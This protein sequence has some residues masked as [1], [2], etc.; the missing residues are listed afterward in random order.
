MQPCESGRPTDLQRMTEDAQAEV[1]GIQRDAENSFLIKLKPALATIAQAKGV[2]LILNEDNDQLAW[3][4]PSLD[5]T[6]DV[7]NRWR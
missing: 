5:I 2:E 1:E 3:F 6:S 4:S 7:V